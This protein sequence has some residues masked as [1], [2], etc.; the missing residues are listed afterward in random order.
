MNIFQDNQNYF[1]PFLT[2]QRNQSTNPKLFEPDEAFMLGNLFK[3]LYMTY[4]G[5][6]NYCIQSMSQREKSLLA[7]QIYSFVAHEINLYLDIYPDN[8][9]M[10][11]LYQQYASKAKEAAEAYE[12]Q[13]GPLT[14]QNSSTQIPFEWVQGPWPWE[15]QI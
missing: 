1:H 2:S 3:D 15:Y 13:F 10:I 4:K 14:V 11:E 9:K 5:F 6:S 12:K 8:K 7:V